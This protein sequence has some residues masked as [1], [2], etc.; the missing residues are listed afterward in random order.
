ML[1]IEGGG[2]SC[3]FWGSV[4][5]MSWLRNLVPTYCVRVEAYEDIEFILYVGQ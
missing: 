2:M 5:V 4:A 3:A 1:E